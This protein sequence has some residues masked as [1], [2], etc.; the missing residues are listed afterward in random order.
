[1][2][3]VRAGYL[4]RSL[5]DGLENN[6]SDQNLPLRQFLGPPGRIHTSVSVLDILLRRQSASFPDTETAYASTV[7]SCSQLKDPDHYV[8]AV[9]ALPDSYDAVDVP[10]EGPGAAESLAS[11]WFPYGSAGVG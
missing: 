9:V 6:P 11:W 1:M 3:A 10:Q 4:L 2:E 5:A 8:V 7:F